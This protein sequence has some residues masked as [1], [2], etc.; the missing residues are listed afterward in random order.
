MEEIG[1]KTIKG[2]KDSL[3]IKRLFL[4]FSDTFNPNWNSG[5]WKTFYF[6]THTNGNK[7]ILKK[8]N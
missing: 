7:Q 6:E 2:G 1:P 3:F 5:C 8:Q 4:Y